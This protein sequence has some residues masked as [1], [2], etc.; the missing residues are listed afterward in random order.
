M[1]KVLA[2]QA[3]GYEYPYTGESIDV[4]G[5]YSIYIQ[6]I[7]IFMCIK[8]IIYRFTKYEWS[9]STWEGTQYV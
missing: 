3:R 9:V 7:N 5:V 4:C 2:I 1:S 6:Y 8:T